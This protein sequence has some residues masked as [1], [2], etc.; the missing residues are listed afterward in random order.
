MRRVYHGSV[1]HKI[2]A[3]L[4]GEYI[5]LRPATSSLKDMISLCDMVDKE[6]NNEYLELMLHSSE[7]M[8]NGSP[9]FPDDESINMLYNNLDCLFKFVRKLGYVGITLEDY[10]INCRKN[11]Q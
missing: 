4:Q 9:Y 1:K 10:C 11:K 3:L 2:K 5:W 7:L 6:V 8:P